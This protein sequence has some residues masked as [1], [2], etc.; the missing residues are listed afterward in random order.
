MKHLTLVVLLAFAAPLIWGE[1]YICTTKAA[2]AFDKDDSGKVN[3][4]VNVPPITMNSNGF[5]TVQEGERDVFSDRCEKT[6]ALLTD[7]Y[8]CISANGAFIVKD[9]EFQAMLSTKSEPMLLKGKCVKL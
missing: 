7:S 1:S 6:G 5:Y 8:Q 9:G 3:D 4:V 2:I